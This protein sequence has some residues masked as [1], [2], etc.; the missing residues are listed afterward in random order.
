MNWQIIG[1]RVAPYTAL[2]LGLAVIAVI[3]TMYRLRRTARSTSYGFVREQSLGRAKR[4]TILAPFLLILL[5]ASVALWGVSLRNPELLPTPMPTPTLTPIPT[6]TPRTPTPTFTPTATPTVTPTPTATPVPPEGELPAV[7]LHPL[8]T[9]AVDPGPDAALIELVLAASQ[10][11]DQPVNPTTRFPPGTERVYAFF[12]F[13]GMARD[14]PWA[15]IWYGKGEGQMVEFW[16]Q[17]ELWPYD[18]ARGRGWRYFNCRPGEYELHIYVGRQLQQ[19]VP[20][21]VAE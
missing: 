17:L 8:P 1:S 15:H 20:F 4:L 5:G 12:T 7:L 14:V 2:G 16:S 21:T 3:V 19:K 9:Q 10:E 11:G 6:P 13:D 18:A